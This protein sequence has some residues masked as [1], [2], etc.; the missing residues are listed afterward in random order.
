MGFCGRPPPRPARPPGAAGAGLR[1]ATSR[2][3]LVDELRVFTPRLAPTGALYPPVQPP[4]S[5]GRSQ[6]HRVTN[7]YRFRLS[8]V[9]ELRPSRALR[10]AAC[11]RA[12]AACCRCITTGDGGAGSLVTLGRQRGLA[13]APLRHQPSPAAP[14]PGLPGFGHRSRARSRRRNRPV[15]DYGA[16]RT[17]RRPRSSP[18][19]C[20]AHRS[21]STSA[22][23]SGRRIDCWPI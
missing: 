19:T 6:C 22:R 16:H 14:D 13:R 4:F 11:D 8:M 18:P 23:A 7:L 15:V 9:A 2:G 5:L 20:S 17:A 10:C 1:A 12:R 21:R 3:L